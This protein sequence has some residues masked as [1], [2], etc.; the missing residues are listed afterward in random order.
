L[1]SGRRR[2]ITAVPHRHTRTSQQ[3]K[4]PS[5]SGSIIT[6]HTAPRHHQHNNTSNTSPQQH[7]VANIPQPGDNSNTEVNRGRDH[8]IGTRRSQV[9]CLAEA[10]R[11]WAASGRGRARTGRPP[12]RRPGGV[13]RRRGRRCLSGDGAGSWS[14]S[15]AGSGQRR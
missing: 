12:G 13:T 6:P 8:G 4:P 9:A 3:Q 11:T 5:H 10:H 7:R 1:P 15:R 2:T 14:S